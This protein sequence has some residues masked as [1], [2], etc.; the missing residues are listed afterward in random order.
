MISYNDRF[1]FI[2]FIEVFFRAISVVF[3]AY[4]LEPYEAGQFGL[5]VT[6]QGIASV[7]FG[8]ERHID[9]QRK[10]VGETDKVFDSAVRL[11]FFIFL[12]N[13][14]L[15]LP[16]YFLGLSIAAK[17][18]FYTML[19]CLIIAIAEQLMNFAY[20]IALVNERY[21]KF[22]YITCAK[23]FIFFVL[24]FIIWFQEK[25]DLEIV[26]IVWVSLATIFT[27]IMFILWFSMAKLN[28][29]EIKNIKSSIISQYQISRSHFFIGLIAILALQLDRIVVGMV[30][31]LDMV[32]IYFRH[33]LIVSLIYQVFNIASY[34]RILPNIFRL[35][36][37]QTIS[38]IRSRLAREYINI[39]V[40]IILLILLVGIL[41]TY[42]G[43]IFFER[44]QINPFLM[45]GLLFAAGV[46]VR[47]DLNNLVFH[48][49]YREDIVLKMQIFILLM[50]SLFLT[51]LTLYL[52][53]LGAIIASAMVAV[54]YLLLSYINLNS[55]RSHE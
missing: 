48:A 24:L 3:V 37:T 41:Y 29:L 38:I 21:A 20:Q 6:L 53:L 49:F 43:Y 22:L 7:L 54:I 45:L 30:M 46:R 17:I 52:G 44:F 39:L 42:G 15:F 31:S 35:A 18:F 19:I 4:T 23:N 26:L 28:K 51:I 13:Y 25:L 10:Y 11:T 16:I 5:I 36:K 9:I 27:I 8:F 50:S 12:T 34:N 33:I 32:G 14:I 40:F 47:A 55:L 2:K 1:V